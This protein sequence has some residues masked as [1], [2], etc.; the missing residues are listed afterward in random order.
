MLQVGHWHCA[1]HHYI[2]HYIY[3]CAQSFSR[4]RLFPTPWTVAPQAPLP[5]GFSRQE[6]WSRLTFPPPRDLPGPGIE[7]VSPVCTALQAGCLPLNS[8]TNKEKGLCISG[9][10]LPLSLLE[11]ILVLWSDTLGKNVWDGFSGKW[12]CGRLTVIIGLWEGGLILPPFGLRGLW[13][14]F[15]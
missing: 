14:L 8:K 4:V 1:R 9:Q 5:V 2:L 15:D 6:H 11:S 10:M 12:H 3:V 7:P 13:G